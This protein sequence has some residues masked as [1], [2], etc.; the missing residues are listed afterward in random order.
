MDSDLI[1][2][3]LAENGSATELISRLIP[4]GISISVITYLE[5]FQG[6]LRSGNPSRS[7]QQLQSLTDNLP[8]LEIDSPL[9]FD[10]N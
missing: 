8:V 2:D 6:T 7:A 10:T 5:A 9:P 1:I 3:H 4:E